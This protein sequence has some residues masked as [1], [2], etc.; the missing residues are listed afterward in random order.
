MSKQGSV[1][2]SSCHRG[3]SNLSAVAGAGNVRTNGSISQC[4]DDTSPS[5]TE[6]TWGRAR[7]VGQQRRRRAVDNEWSVIIEFPQ[8]V[9]VLPAELVALEAHLGAAIDAILAGRN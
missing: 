8:M 4:S 5:R 6:R 7:R 1:C 2:G 3:Q 9:P